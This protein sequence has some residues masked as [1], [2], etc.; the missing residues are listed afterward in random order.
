M[1]PPLLLQCHSHGLLLSTRALMHKTPAITRAVWQSRLAHTKPKLRAGEKSPLLNPPASTRP[2]ILATPER[3]RS[4]SAASY[5]FNL[6][7]A[8]LKFYKDGLKAVFQNR[9]LLKEKLDRTPVDDRPSIY[10]PH[11]V[12]KSF[13][14]ADWV[15]FWR[16]KHDMLRLPFFGL[17]LLVIGEFTALVVLWVDGVVPY[18][19]RIPKQIGNNLQ[20]AEERRKLVFNELEA[21]YPQGVLSPGVNTAVARKHVL[22]SLHIAGNMWDRLGF[23]PP[24]MWGIK[25]NLRMAFLEGDD[26]N[27][28]EDGGIMGLEADELRIACAERGINTLGRS[29]NDLRRWLGDWL[30]LTAAEDIQERRRRMATLL[31][32]R[33]VTLRQEPV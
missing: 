1:A 20:Q 29:D 19:C 28:V 14:R 27:I 30:R 13:S 3:S 15:L 4:D 18:T 11:Y 33:Y 31:L 16:V 24:G 12:P 22:R 7:K 25:G 32:T 26:K 17:M 6:G 23:I 9:R 10:K 8:Y 5:Y 2:P 21:K